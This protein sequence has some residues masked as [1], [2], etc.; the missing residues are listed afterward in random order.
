M[1]NFSDHQLAKNIRKAQLATTYDPIVPVQSARCE[2]IIQSRDDQLKI[3]NAQQDIT[4]GAGN[5]NITDINCIWVTFATRTKNT[6]ISGMGRLWYGPIKPLQRTFTD[7]PTAGDN[8]CIFWVDGEAYYI[9]ILNSD[10]GLQNNANM[11]VTNKLIE[12]GQSDI[13]TGTVTD[14]AIF[15][16]PDTLRANGLCRLEKIYHQPIDDPNEAYDKDGMSS[17]EYVKG[18]GSIGD[19]YVEGK[20]GSSIRLG[21]RDN[22]PLLFISNNRIKA[23]NEAGF[24]AAFESPTDGGF[25]GM[26]S[27]YTLQ[28]SLLQTKPYELECNNEDK[29]KSDRKIEWTDDQIQYA[30]DQ[31]LLS[32]DRII[33]NSR[34]DNTYVSSGKDINIG[35]ANNVNI[36]TN[37]ALICETE[38]IYLGKEA[39]NKEE[40]MVLG[41]QLVELL[42]KLID[43]IG[44]LNVAG[45]IAGFSAP[46]TS[47]PAYNATVKPL[48]REL[49]Q[50][51][52][53]KHY[54][55][56]NPK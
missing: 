54:I 29:N 8:V 4:T 50:I 55:E 34:Q 53:K 45:T 2:Y 16:I 49:N 20:F 35:A 24:N 48:I 43:G 3:L 7:V 56:P 11:I 31:M 19:T 9:G 1:S 10:N 13:L 26:F 15:G 18:P 44:Q 23:E 17:E 5:M 33:F 14:K 36:V 46:I 25:F 39:V 28:D 12:S 27:H 52:S 32:S 21:S 38:N 22:H 37:K 42:E 6:P 40:P 51:L 41:T 30:K 47:S